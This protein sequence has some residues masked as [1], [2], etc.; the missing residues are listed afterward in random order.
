MMEMR[1][2]RMV[3]V[4]FLFILVLLNKN[5]YEDIFFNLNFIHQNLKDYCGEK[6]ACDRLCLGTLEILQTL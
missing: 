2:A 5:G 3:R 4:L 1:S 6:F